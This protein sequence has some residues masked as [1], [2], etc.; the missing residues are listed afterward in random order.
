MGSSGIGGG[1]YYHEARPGG[2]ADVT[3]SGGTVYAMGY[4][5]R[6]DIGSGGTGTDGSLTIS[7]DAAVF[8]CYD[9]TYDTVSTSTHTHVPRNA[10]SGG[11]LYGY[12][13]P[14]NWTSVGAYLNFDYLLTYDPGE[15]TGVNYGVQYPGGTVTI[16]GGDNFSRDTYTFAG[17]EDSEG[18]EYEVGSSDDADG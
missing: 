16:E 8:L 1:S 18:A 17:W 7:G 2:G 15:G 9:N 3:I 4:Y 6:N 5:Y 11:T 13:M 10:V 14:T 12:T